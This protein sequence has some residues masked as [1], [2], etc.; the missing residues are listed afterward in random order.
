MIEVK[1][2]GVRHGMAYIAGAYY[3]GS[4]VKMDGVFSQSDINALP[5]GQKNIPG[6]ASVN[7]LKLTQVTAAADGQRGLVYP[8]NKLVYQPEGSDASL[9]LIPAGAGVIF[10]QGGQFETDQFLAVSGTAGGDF[11]DN[12]EITVSGKLTESSEADTSLQVVA[13]VVKMTFGDD[14]TDDVKGYMHDKDLL[15][16]TLL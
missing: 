14:Y 11:G 5:T 2:P 10:Y 7:S 12:L 1:I 15:W 6:F 3:K 13:K 9:D 8:I 4:F 16:Y